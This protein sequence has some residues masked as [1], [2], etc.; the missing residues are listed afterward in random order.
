[1]VVAVL[2]GR[3]EHHGDFALQHELLIGQVRHQLLA[4]LLQIHFGVAVLSRGNSGVEVVFGPLGGDKLPHLVLH[5]GR[6]EG[7]QAQLH[8]G[9]RLLPFQRPAA[10]ELPQRRN[11]IQQLLQAPLVHG[12]YRVFDEPPHPLLELP[13]LFAA[14]VGQQVL[15]L[16]QA[17]VGDAAA[18][19]SERFDGVQQMYER[20]DCGR[21]VTHVL[22]EYE[23]EAAREVLAVFEQAVVE[24]GQSEPVEI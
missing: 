6:G 19:V 13:Q 10:H 12:E 5:V 24:E 8:V 16:R 11:R 14:E 2:D 17:D 4:Q 7:G 3:V 23:V 20:F 9:R 22:A 21:V 18:V 1:M 15:D